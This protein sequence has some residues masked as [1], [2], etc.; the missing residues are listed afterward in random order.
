M[1][2]FSLMC[3][4]RVICLVMV[5]VCMCLIIIYIY[6]Y[7]FSSGFPFVFRM[8]YLLIMCHIRFV[9]SDVSSYVSLPSPP[10]SSYVFELCRVALLR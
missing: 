7:I 3:V 5:L 8:S 9:M 4:V 1:F 2:R 6:I 10:V